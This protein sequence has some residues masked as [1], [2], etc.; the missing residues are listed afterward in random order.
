MRDL[1]LEVALEDQFVVETDLVASI[2]L[3]EIQ[4][5]IGAAEN[6]HRRAVVCRRE[7]DADR[8]AADLRE[9]VFLDGGAEALEHMRGLL[10][11]RGPEQDHK[12]FAA[13]SEH[14][15]LRAK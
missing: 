8:D 3:G 15:V 5:L 11:R 13:E 2:G 14:P 1:G 12:L 4:G 10:E 9:H 7:A 6:F